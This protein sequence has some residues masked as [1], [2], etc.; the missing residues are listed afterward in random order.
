VSFFKRSRP[1]PTPDG[2]L[3][4]T[5]E[6]ART[7]RGLVRTAFAETGVEVVVHAGHVEDDQGG[8]FGLWNLAALCN[9]T[10]ERE[11]PDVV[12]AHVSRLGRPEEVE[13]MSEDALEQAIH[14]RLVESAGL[15]NPASHPSATR[16]G[17]D[18]TALL[19]VDLPHTVS[20]PQEA[21]WAGRGG[22]DRWLAIGRANLRALLI[23]DALEHQRV[24]PPDGQGAF[25]VVVGESFFTASTALL[26]DDL[27]RRF[28]PATDVSRGVLL[29]V[30]FRHQVAYRV[31]DGTRDGVVA[32]NNLLHFAMLGFR[33]A[34]GPLSPNVFWVRDGRWVQ[35][36]RIVDEQPRVEIDEELAAALGALGG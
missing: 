24:A 16:Y 27:V 20:T 17:D 15:P 6:Q 14:L 25:D 33:E 21:F 7:L 8:Q 28:A 12:R 13:T 18:L 11:W 31:L 3:P 2:D 35:V 34:P 4:L 29:V 19:S 36:S 22:R 32:L 9:D 5:A 30:P 23:S 1:E 26:S 10:P